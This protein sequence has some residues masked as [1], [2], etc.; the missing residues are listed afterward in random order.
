MP[1]R[2]PR[3]ICNPENQGQTTISV[4]RLAV[5]SVLLALCL[6]GALWLVW[7]F[8]SPDVPQQLNELVLRLFDPA[9]TVTLML[10]HNPHAFSGVLWFGCQVIEIFLILL[11]FGAM[12][13]FIARRMHGVKR[14]SPD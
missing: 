4:L 5:W 2:P 8:L 14:A 11:V 7:W 3:T 13:I 1:T 9:L 6:V 10:S 12:G